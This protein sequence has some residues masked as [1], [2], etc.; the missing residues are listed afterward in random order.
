M[1]ESIKSAQRLAREA[2]ESLPKSRRLELRGYWVTHRDRH[3]ATAAETEDED[4]QR[5][6]EGMAQPYAEAIDHLD[7]LEK[8]NT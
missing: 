3:R 4:K 2:Y 6:F 7:F 1:S 8:E 5:Y